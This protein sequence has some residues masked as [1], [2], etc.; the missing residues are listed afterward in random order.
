LPFSRPTHKT[1]P[2]VYPTRVVKPSK[3]PELRAGAG[4]CSAGVPTRDQNAAE[5]SRA[6]KTRLLIR[7]RQRQEPRNTVR[8]P[9]SEVNPNRKSAIE[10]PKGSL[11]VS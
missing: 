11:P 9:K 6:T 10:N 5:D 1:T 7:Q 8:G 4:I 3:Q 2:S